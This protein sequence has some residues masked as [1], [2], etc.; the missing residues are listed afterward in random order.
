MLQLTRKSAIETAK[1]R[2]C[3]VT[4]ARQWRRVPHDIALAPRK[5]PLEIRRNP[6]YT[7]SYAAVG[8][9]SC[10]S[11]AVDD[12]P[13]TRYRPVAVHYP[14]SHLSAIVHDLASMPLSDQYELMALQTN[15]G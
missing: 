2:P 4:R 7:C 13:G 5:S 6:W 9:P 15:R 1:A 8:D 12:A 10:P 3:T 11:T 14:A